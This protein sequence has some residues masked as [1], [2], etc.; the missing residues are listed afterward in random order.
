[1]DARTNLLRVL[2]SCLVIVLEDEDFLPGQIRGIGVQPL[3]SAGDVRGR[4]ITECAVFI[5]KLSSSLLEIQRVFL[6]LCYQGHIRPHQRRK[7]ERDANNPIHVPG[8]PAFAIGTALLKTLRLRKANTLIDHLPGCIAVIVIPNDPA[9]LRLAGPGRFPPDGCVDCGPAFCVILACQLALKIENAAAHITGMTEPS[10]DLQFDR[11]RRCAVVMEGTLDISPR[12]DSLAGKPRLKI[13]AGLL[14]R[15]LERRTLRPFR[16]RRWVWWRL[17]LRRGCGSRHYTKRFCV[18]CLPIVG[19]AGH[20]EPLRQD[21]FNF[22]PGNHPPQASA[23]I[24]AAAFSRHCCGSRG[25]S[26]CCFSRGRPGP[27]APSPSATNRSNSDSRIM[28]RLPIFVRRS[29]PELNH[30]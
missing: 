19:A 14:E 16:G 22:A 20:S 9:S 4:G 5:R 18:S 28:T 17:D 29:L 13:S 2:A 27:F 15:G 30:A 8:P 7:I 21:A 10:A 11:H 25:C 23:P 24:K 1:M 6:A 3:A 12:T 26:G